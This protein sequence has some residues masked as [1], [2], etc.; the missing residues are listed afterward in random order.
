MHDPLRTLTEELADRRAVTP[1]ERRASRWLVEVLRRSTYQVWVEPFG[2]FRSARPAWA[3]ILGLSL[4]GGMLVRPTPGAGLGLTLLGAVGFAAQSLG[5]LQF[6]WLFPA[7]ESQNVVGVIPAA[8]EIRQRVVVVAHY[9]TGERVW[10]GPAFLSVA[11]AVMSLPLAAM[12]AAVLPGAI[13]DRLVLLPLI[14]VVGGLTALLRP[15]RQYGNAAGVAA[16]LAV[17]R[18]AP[19]THTEVWTLFTGSRAPGLVGIQAFLLRHGRLLTEGH[20][21]VLE[22]EAGEG[23][24]LWQRRGEAAVIAERP[25]RAVTLL[26]VNRSDIAGTAARVRAMAEAVDREAGQEMGA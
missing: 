10:A 25:H 12:A 17:G 16:A 13:W 14:G 3:V 15:G 8:D 11:V 24:T 9:D 7:G 18:S 1:G 21:I 4:L 26:P 5:W 6:G 19:L 20:F 22:E 23:A 2:S